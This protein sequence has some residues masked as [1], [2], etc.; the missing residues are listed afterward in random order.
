MGTHSGR[1]PD[2]LYTC[3]GCGKTKQFQPRP[4]GTKPTHCRYCRRIE[5]SRQPRVRVPQVV[6]DEG[7]CNQ[8]G[9]VDLFYPDKGGSNKKA[10][11]VCAACPVRVQC[12]QYA[13]EAGEQFGIWGGLSEQERTALRRRNR[14]EK[15]A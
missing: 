1:R 3:Q 8:I 6:I 5:I 4:N 2:E 13:L 11:A 9:D 12:L 14:Q 10:K 7:T 15:A